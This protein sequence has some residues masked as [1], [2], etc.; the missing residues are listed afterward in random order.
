MNKDEKLEIV[1]QIKELINNST[2]VY[3]IDYAGV[4]VADISQIRREFRKEKVVYKVFKNTLV[5][6]AIAESNKFDKLDAVLQGMNGFAFVE[7][8]ISAPAKIIKKYK[9][10][11]GKLNLKGC[12]IEDQFY[13]GDKLNELASLPSKEE[14]I[15]SVIGSIVAP[16]SGVVGAVGAVMR[17]LVNV[18]DA[19]EKKKAA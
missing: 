14:V 11:S 13:S 4:N 10:V 6:K 19:I 12:Y 15:S 3:V 9:D 18:I 1:S 2:A 16:I 7:E 17:D 5:Q 8:N